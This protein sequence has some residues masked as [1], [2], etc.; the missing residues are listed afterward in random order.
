MK[1]VVYDGSY[2]GLLTAV[3]EIYEY[4]FNEAVIQKKDQVTTLLFG[5]IHEVVS[6]PEKSERVIKRLKEKISKNSLKQIFTTYL[7]EEKNIENS[8]LRYIQYVMRSKDPVD[9]DYSNPDVLVVQ[10]MSRKVHREKH[11]MEAFIRFQL[12]KDQIYYAIIQP[13][14]NVLP[15]ISKHFEERYA[16]QQWLIYDV[17]RKYGYFYNKENVEEVQVN[18]SEGVNDAGNKHMIFDEKEELYQKLWQQYFSSVNIAARK[19]M[20]LHI[21]HMPKRYWKYLMEK[22]VT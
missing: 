8:L 7:S 20:K 21:Q 19:N 3:F 5:D 11:R 18:F 12:T 22:K 2:E 10:Q 16:D 14:Y 9:N 13:D 1:T 15:L 17:A 4:R 6:N